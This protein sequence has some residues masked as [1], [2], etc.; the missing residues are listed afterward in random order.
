MAASATMA[1]RQGNT[2]EALRLIEEFEKRYKRE[3]SRPYSPTEKQIGL[4]KI[5]KSHLKNAA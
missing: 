1:S 4:M 2:T 3:P 5:K